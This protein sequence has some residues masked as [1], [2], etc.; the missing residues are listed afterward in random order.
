M[1]WLVPLLMLLILLIGFVRVF[2]E[3]WPSIFA[4]ASTLGGGLSTYLMYREH[5]STG[6]GGGLVAAQ[7]TVWFWLGLAASLAVSVAGLLFYARQVRP[8]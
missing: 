4:L 2:W 7:M 8:P 3:Q 5:L 1:L 6:S